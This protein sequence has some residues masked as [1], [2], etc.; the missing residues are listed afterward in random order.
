[1]EDTRAR[2][3]LRVCAV[4]FLNTAPLVWGM[5]HG[6]Q[7]G[8]FD[9]SF[10]TPAVC[11]DRLER[12]EADIGI[13]PAIELE[14]LGLET[15]PGVCIASRGPVRS[16][17]LASKKPLDEI[18][19]LAADSSSRTSAMLARV[20]LAERYGVQPRVT[21]MAPDLNSMLATADAALVIGD[22][23]LHI[24]PGEVPYEVYDLG[25]E[26]TRWTGK[27]MV[28]AVWA[29]RP[30]LPLRELEEAFRGSAAYGLERI[31]DIVRKE[32]PRRGIP[33]A[34]AREYLAHRIRFAFGRD[35][36]EGLALFLEYASRGV[37]A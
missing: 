31:G 26:W 7:R 2:E 10:E 12:G 9:L 21:A 32:A 23:A 22:P 25:E 1:M 8:L 11:A 13:V 14:R 37:T 5:L 35:E 33:E 28:F 19:T 29:G 6:E 15:I 3:R 34:L 24:D 36:E 20:V 27:P 18:R 4:R 17:L 16:I 30:G